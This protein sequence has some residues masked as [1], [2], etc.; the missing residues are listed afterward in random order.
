M[1]INRLIPALIIMLTAS[2]AVAVAQDSRSELQHKYAQVNGIKLHYVTSGTGKTILFLHGFPEFWY[3]WRKQLPEFGSLG[4][5]AVA[6]DMRGYNLSEKPPKVEDYIVP[7]LIAD[8]KGMLDTVSKGRKA[9]LVAHDWGGAVAWAFAASHPEMLE[10]L[11]IINAPHPAVF[12]RELAENPKQQAASGYMNFFRSPQAEGLLSADNYK[13]LLN[14]VLNSVQPQSR[15]TEADRKAY[16]AAWA[17]PGALTGGLNY[18]RASALGPPEPGKELDTSR[19]GGLKAHISVPTLVIWGEKD[20]ALLTGNLVGLDKYVPNLTIRRIPN[21][22]HW[23]IHEEPELVNR[24]IEAFI[25][26]ERIP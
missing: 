20:T 2:R 14:A 19:L 16:L 9:I 7:T 25:K 1:G 4:Y 12:M 13:P 5:Q 24:L 10:K 11:V 23:V 22:S 26:G 6:F 8:V 3:S 18:Y 17:Q 15:V 21:G